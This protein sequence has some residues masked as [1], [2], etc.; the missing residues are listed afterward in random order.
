M[1]GVEGGVTIVYPTREM[2]ERVSDPF[3]QNGSHRADGLAVKGLAMGTKDVPGLSE[4]VSATWYTPSTESGSNEVEMVE[5][6]ARRG[7][8]DEED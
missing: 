3:C 7:D 4:N 8:H 5:D 6:G 1:D 2:A